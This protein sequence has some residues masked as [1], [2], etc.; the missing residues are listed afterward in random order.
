[1]RAQMTGNTENV[2]SEIQ[3][4]LG[5]KVGEPVEIADIGADGLT[6]YDGFIVGAPT[7]HT[8]ADDNRSGTSWDDELANIA[9]L[10]LNGKPCAIFGLGDSAGY[11]DYFCD[12]IEEVHNTFKS[13][14]CNMVG[15]VSAD[16]YNH[17]GSKSEV[18][19]KFLGCPFDED[20]EGDQTEERAAAWG[21]QLEEEMAGAF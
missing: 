10:D 4:A 18:D 6:D 9:A 8:D 11:A 21:K 17:A 16:G 1:M 14:G 19:G 13:A 15:Y 3:K 12:A 20:N 5:D 7:W 2:A